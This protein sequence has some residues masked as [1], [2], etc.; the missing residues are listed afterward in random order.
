MNR[1]ASNKATPAHRN[2]ML[3]VN[4][5]GQAMTRYFV[6]ALLPPHK[7]MLNSRLNAIAA[8]FLDCDTARV[9]QPGTRLPMKFVPD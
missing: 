6:A 4:T 3:P 8:L 9:S 1:I 5:G 2:R 7:I